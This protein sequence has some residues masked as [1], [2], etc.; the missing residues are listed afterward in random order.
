MERLVRAF[1][2]RFG[3]ELV[4]EMDG[5]EF[6]SLD[7][8]SVCGDVIQFPVS[9]FLFCREANVF[10]FQSHAPNRDH[11]NFLTRVLDFAIDHCN[12]KELCTVGGVISAITH[13][14]PRNVFGIVNQPGLKETLTHC[15]VQTNMDYETPSGGGTSISNFLLWVA[16]TRGLAGCTLWVEV[17]FYLAATQDPMA[18]RRVFE[19]LNC[20]FGLGL[21]LHGVGLE[22]QRLDRE[23]DDLRAQNHEIA[24]YLDLL[25]RGIMLSEGEGETLA[26]EVGRFLH[27]KL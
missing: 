13:A 26:R 7:G 3:T 22:A 10:I 9:R 24:R 2:R 21:D 19:V 17:P 8:V 16:K 12:V 15:D 27:K 1:D 6:F 4:E 11:Y 5:A 20:R 14:S 23:I 25:E 18:L